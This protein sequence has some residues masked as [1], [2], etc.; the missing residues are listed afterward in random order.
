MA[1]TVLNNTAAM[2]TL[3]ELGHTV[4]N[5]FKRFDRKSNSKT[6][7]ERKQYSDP[8]GNNSIIGIRNP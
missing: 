6:K 7:T 5:G 4:F 3:G 1:M 2:M 8:T